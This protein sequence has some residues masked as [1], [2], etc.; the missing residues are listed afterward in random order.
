MS[1]ELAI[2]AVVADEK[3][4]AVDDRTDFVCSNSK[5]WRCNEDTMSEI[6]QLLDFY[7]LV[8]FSTVNV[9]ARKLFGRWCKHQLL[10]KIPKRIKQ[11]IRSISNSAII[12]FVNE[13]YIARFT[14]LFKCAAEIR[15][16]NKMDDYAPCGLSHHNSNN[17]VTVPKSISW[18]TKSEIKEGQGAERWCITCYNTG[19]NKFGYEYDE[20]LDVFCCDNCGLQVMAR[21]IVID[22]ECLCVWCLEEMDK[23]VQCGTCSKPKKIQDLVVDNNFILQCLEGCEPLCYICKKVRKDSKEQW[24]RQHRTGLPLC[25]KCSDG[26][27][28]AVAV[29]FGNSVQARAANAATDPRLQ[30][31]TDDDSLAWHRIYDEWGARFI[32]D[33][34]K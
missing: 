15:S 8:Q 4:S 31:I 16:R 20:L 33:S 27:E 23:K 18:D 11:S 22:C 24:F 19:R 3:L 21:N 10:Y 29:Q 14:R 30:A 6:F 28:G 13:V 2:T 26:V 34:V 25:G 17:M 5:G 32:G 9:A 1:T 12:H 7:S